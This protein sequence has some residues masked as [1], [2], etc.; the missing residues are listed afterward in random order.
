[1]SCNEGSTAAG[2]VRWE[3]QQVWD[4]DLHCPDLDVQVEIGIL[5]AGG[6]GHMFDDLFTL[7]T[8]LK[9]GA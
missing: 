6:G 4:I 5:D 2:M 1:M 3:T 8:K 7:Y 9:A